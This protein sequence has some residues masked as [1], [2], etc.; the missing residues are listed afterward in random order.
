MPRPEQRPTSFTATARRSTP[1]APPSTP[2]WGSP[3][4]PRTSI[5]CKRLT[6]TAPARLPPPVTGGTSPA[7]PTGLN[8]TGTTTSSVSLAWNAST[9][10]TSYQLY[11]NGSQIYSNSS[12]NYA[13]TGIS[14]GTTYQY[15]VRATNSYGSSALS[16]AVPGKTDALTQICFWSNDRTDGT[17]TV[18]VDGSSVGTVTN[19]FSSQ[20]SWGRCRN[21]G[22]DRATRNTHTFCNVS[23]KRNVDCTIRYL[24]NGSAADV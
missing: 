12:T 7:T 11:R 24:D 20:P 9:G 21:L 23:R 6:H 22:R 4:A 3:P 8:V 19:W 17:I 18:Y 1:T 5:R 13:D 2:I 15:T 10:A 16:N 14:W